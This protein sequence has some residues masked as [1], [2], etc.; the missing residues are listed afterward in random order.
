MPCGIN[1][2]ARTSLGKPVPPDR[3]EQCRRQ[4]NRLADARGNFVRLR[5]D[6]WFLAIEESPDPAVGYQGL[7]YYH[8]RTC[9]EI[10]RLYDTAAE[11]T[12]D[13]FLPRL[14]NI[15]SN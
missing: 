8:Q 5:M 6:G 4:M 13:P 14:R 7:G 1:L 9:W 15:L 11:R 12:E 10:D 2:F 3:L